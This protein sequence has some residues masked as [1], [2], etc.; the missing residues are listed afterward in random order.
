MLDNSLRRAAEKCRHFD[1]YV[2]LFTEIYWSVDEVVQKHKWELYSDF[3]KSPKI[4]I[5]PICFHLDRK[6]KRKYN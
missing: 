1:E 4:I 5:S 3:K 2:C 6:E